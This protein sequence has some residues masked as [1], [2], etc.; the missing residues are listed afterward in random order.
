MGQQGGQFLADLG[1]P[2]VQAERIEFL[3]QL[4]LA[5][6]FP[7]GRGPA[8]GLGLGSLNHALKQFQSKLVEA[9]LADVQFEAGLVHLAGMMSPFDD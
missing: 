3:L 8:V 6:I 7:R 5:G 9:A 1:R 4:D 2:Q